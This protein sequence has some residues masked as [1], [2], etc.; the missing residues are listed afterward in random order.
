MEEWRYNSTSDNMGINGQ[1]NAPA[2]LPFEERVAGPRWIECRSGYEGKEKKILAP[3]RESN[4]GRP[5]CRLVHIL[6]EP[7]MIILKIDAR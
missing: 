1:L 6:S 4:G 3:I 7:H 5:V 2:N